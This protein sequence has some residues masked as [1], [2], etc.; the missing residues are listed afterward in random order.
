MDETTILEFLATTYP[1]IQVVGADGS[2]FFFRGAE[3]N[4]P[5]ATLVTSDLYDQESNLDRE[6]VFRLNIG[7]SRDTYRALFPEEG[8]HDFC[9]TNRLMPHPV[10]G[11]MFWVCVLNPSVE[12]FEEAV[13][14]LLAEAHE[15][16]VRK[17]N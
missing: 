7:V 3:R 5:L 6:G 17:S 13:K 15:K 2:Y 10:Y 4:F 9:A 12:T 8:E 11:K 1:D 16:A 14:P